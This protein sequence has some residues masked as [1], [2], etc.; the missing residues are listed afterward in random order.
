[1]SRFS[2]SFPLLI[3]LRPLLPCSRAQVLHTVILKDIKPIAIFYP[4]DTR[5]LFQLRR[6]FCYTYGE[7]NLSYKQKVTVNCKQATTNLE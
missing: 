2:L 7:Y 3:T 5:L 6:L 1:M 4:L